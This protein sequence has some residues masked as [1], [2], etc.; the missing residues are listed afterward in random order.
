MARTSQ[1]SRIPK[2]PRKSHASK[3][4]ARK[5]SP[6]GS[7]YDKMTVVQLKQLLEDRG[8]DWKLL[9]KSG[10]STHIK[11]DFIDALKENDAGP[12]IPKEKSPPKKS[13]PKEKPGFKPGKGIADMH[14]SPVK[15]S[16]KKAPKPLPEKPKKKVSKP[17]SPEKKDSKQEAIDIMKERVNKMIDIH[18]DIPEWV[19]EKMFRDEYGRE[20]LRSALVNLVDEFQHHFRDNKEADEIETYVSG[21]VLAF[22][23]VSKEWEQLSEKNDDVH[24]DKTSIIFPKKV[25]AYLL[26]NT[27]KDYSPFELEVQFQELIY[28]S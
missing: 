26:S 10:K 4:A 14:P 5:S 3:V 11:K 20:I 15:P 7:E 25:I 1:K 13:P 18:Y 27:G 21:D 28:W 8:V 12:S 24:I 6:S 16:K 2:A 9:P 22:P 17:K 19:N 23:F